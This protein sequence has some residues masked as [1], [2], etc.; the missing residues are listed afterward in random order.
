MFHV[1]Y[2]DVNPNIF[3]VPEALQVVARVSL[4]TN[5]VEQ[6]VPGFDGTDFGLRGGEHFF[7][8]PAGSGPLDVAI[9]SDLRDVPTGVYPY[10]LQSGLRGF[11][12]NRFIGTSTTTRDLLVHVN[13]QNSPFGTAGASWGCSD[14]SRRP[15]AASR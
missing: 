8:I 1:G 3:S 14:C 5:G 12:G 7:S 2:D 10:Q 15:T 9:Q 11:T 6:M 4:N 13:E